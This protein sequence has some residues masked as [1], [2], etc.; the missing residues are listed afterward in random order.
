MAEP[1]RQRLFFALWPDEALRQQLD[2]YRPMLNGC[3]GRL[4]VPENLHITLAFLGSIDSDTRQCLEEAV[5]AIALPAFTLQLNELGFWR[6]PQVV[7]LGTDTMPTSLLDLATAL[8]RAMISCHLEPDE[9][10]FQAHMTLMRKAHRP[11]E[12]S[13]V[14]PLAWPIDDFALV[15]S[16]T[17]AEGVRYEV[18][19]R[20]RLK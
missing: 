10:P 15:R 1:E 16:D 18:L 9:R 14:S 13:S 11:P 4:V 8:K 12:A 7:W 17:R 20:W 2:T 19:R 6:R 5:G 3:G